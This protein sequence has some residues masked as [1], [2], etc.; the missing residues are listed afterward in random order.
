MQALDDVKTQLLAGHET[1]SMMLTWTCWLLA[2]HPDVM[3]RV[4][5]EVDKFDDFKGLEYMTCV[6]KEAMR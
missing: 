1:S 2:K 6:L 5:A 4:V 3:A